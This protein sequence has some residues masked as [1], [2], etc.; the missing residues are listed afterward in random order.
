MHI[1][2]VTCIVNHEGSAQYILDTVQFKMLCGKSNGLD[3]LCANFKRIKY[4]I[5]CFFF[6]FAHRKIINLSI[7]MSGQFKYTVY[8]SMSFLFKI[9]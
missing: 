7:D 9:I 4:A 1:C 5:E 3:R 2:T 8:Y 6:Y